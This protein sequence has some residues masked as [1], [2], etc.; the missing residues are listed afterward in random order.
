MLSASTYPTLLS[1]L[2]QERLAALGIFLG[3]VYCWESV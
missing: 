2:L 1:Q 3:I